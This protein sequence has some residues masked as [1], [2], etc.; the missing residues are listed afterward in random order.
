KPN[1][2][3]ARL[4]RKIKELFG[5]REKVD[6]PPVIKSFAASTTTITLPCQPGFHSSSG[7]CPPNFN[8]TVQ[9]ATVASDPDPRDTVLRYTYS[10]TGGR[11]TGAGANVTWDLS[12]AG[13]GTYTAS[14]E[15]DDGR[16]CVSLASTTVAI[17][18]CHDCATPLLCPSVSVSGPDAV[19]AG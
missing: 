15:V 11:V 19:A 8:S 10:V 2:F 9:L 6:S 7:S 3:F 1:G 17:S 12:G 4:G 16:G 14:V 13:P 18:A 5:W